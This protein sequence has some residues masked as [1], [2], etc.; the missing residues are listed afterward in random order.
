MT[1]FLSATKLLN[2]NPAIQHCPKDPPC[3]RGQGKDGVEVI[4]CKE[5]GMLSGDSICRSTGGGKSD[6]MRPETI[7]QVIRFFC[8][9]DVCVI[10]KIIPR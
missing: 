3:S 1:N 7:T 2:W 4:V 10:G 9:T 8:L 6:T 5:V